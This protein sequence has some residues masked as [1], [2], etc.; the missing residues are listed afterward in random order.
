MLKLCSVT[1]IKVLQSVAAA[2]YPVAAISS[3]M[4]VCMLR[5]EAQHKQQQVYL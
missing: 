1:A 4:C 5:T 2:L 3:S